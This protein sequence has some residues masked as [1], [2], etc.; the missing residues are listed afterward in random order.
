[1]V[2]VQSCYTALQHIVSI[3]ITNQRYLVHY[4]LNSTSPVAIHLPVYHF[5]GR[6]LQCAQLSAARHSYAQSL[7]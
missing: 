5:A 1:M 7:T 2:S 6:S 3:T 4:L